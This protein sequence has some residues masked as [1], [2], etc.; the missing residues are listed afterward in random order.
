[1]ILYTGYSS[2]FRWTRYR[3]REIKWDLCE[4]YFPTPWRGVLELPFPTPRS[5]N[6]C[7]VGSCLMSLRV[8]ESYIEAW[9]FGRLL[10]Q[11]LHKELAFL[12]GKTGIHSS[13]YKSDWNQRFW[14]HMRNYGIYYMKNILQMLWTLL[15]PKLFYNFELI[16]F[17][18]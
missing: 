11:P 9:H 2:S 10:P 14:I 13:I 7:V 1:M 3:Q 12:S 4:K 5:W 8:N 6:W 17:T 18:E 16:V 15:F